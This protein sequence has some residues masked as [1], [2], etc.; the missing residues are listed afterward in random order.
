MKALQRTSLRT[1]DSS[2]ASR[3]PAIFH[4]RLIQAAA[5]LCLYLGCAVSTLRAQPSVTITIVPPEVVAAGA[6]WRLLGETDWRASGIAY[7]NVPLGSHFLEFKPVEGWET[8]TLAWPLQ[9]N[10]TTVAQFMSVGYGEIPVNPISVTETEGGFVEEIAWSPY[11][12]FHST[13]PPGF[14]ATPSWQNAEWEQALK[15]TS[16]S[17]GMPRD[18]SGW[19]VQL[20]A[21]AFPGYQFVGW[22]GDVTGTRNPLRFI[23]TGPRRIQAHFA[24]ASGPPKATYL[25]DYCYSPGIATIHGQ[26]NYRIGQRLVSLEWRPKLPPGWK[27]VGVSGLGGPQ[28]Q[29]TDISFRALKGQNP[30]QFNL[31]V[32]VPADETGFREIGGE[33]EYVLVD[34]DQAHTE[35]IWPLAIEVRPSPAARLA[36]D[37]SSDPPRLTVHGAVGKT[38]TLEQTPKLWP[39]GSADQL[40]AFMGDLTLTNSTQI[41]VDPYPTAVGGN[42]FY[43][44]TLMEE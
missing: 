37:L 44:A 8:P 36:V 32:E 19:R 34:P 2:S 40:W 26:F 28:L 21:M 27:L 5:V 3:G 35:T 24:R 7:T 42:I 9:V 38:Y 17:A 30:L 23:I 33:V 11:S 29:G 18:N 25:V 6:A 39:G 13:Q 1:T 43:R 16:G 12:S 15:G 41:F 20:R 22:S 4:R 10:T 14:I 31:N